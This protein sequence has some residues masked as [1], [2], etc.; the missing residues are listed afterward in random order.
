[1]L[2]PHRS[3]GGDEGDYSDIALPTPKRR[4]IYTVEG[5]RLDNSNGADAL[6]TEKPISTGKNLPEFDETTYKYRASIYPSSSAQSISNGISSRCSPAQATEAGD[7][8]ESSGKSQKICFGM[9]SYYR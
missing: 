5:T 6:N 3:Y 9:V 2:R 1:M 8:V 7:V 4:K